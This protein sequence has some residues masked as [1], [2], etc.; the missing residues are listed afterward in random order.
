MKKVKVKAL[1]SFGGGE[2]HL[3]KDEI[4]EVPEE[5]AQD[6]IKYGLAEKVK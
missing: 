4:I 6:W 1:Q 3:T 5:I 2:Y